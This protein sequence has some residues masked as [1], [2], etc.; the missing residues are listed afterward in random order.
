MRSARVRLPQHGSKLLGSPIQFIP[1]R[2]QQV[3]DPS[4]LWYACQGNLFPDSIRRHRLDPG[5]G[6]I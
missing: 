6:G 3:G 4:P 2:Q 5:D 1:C